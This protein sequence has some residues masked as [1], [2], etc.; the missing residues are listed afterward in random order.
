MD[1]SFQRWVLLLYIYITSFNPSSNPR[2]ETDYNHFQM[3]Q[4]ERWNDTWGAPR[5][6]TS[7]SL[8]ARCSFSWMP[9]L[10]TVFWAAPGTQE[11]LLGRDWLHEGSLWYLQSLNIS[12]SP[13]AGL[14]SDVLHKDAR[15]DA[16]NVHKAFSGEKER[17]E[18]SLCY[19]KML[20][21]KNACCENKT[22]LTNEKDKRH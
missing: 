19:T 6:R 21:S 16:V 7:F 4:A 17:T 1:D 2:K 14:P 11:T 15:C 3:R 10:R 9:A 20:C 8:L 12:I 5:H 13:T 18:K 22:H